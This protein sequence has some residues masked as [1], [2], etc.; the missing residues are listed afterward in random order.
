MK[1]SKDS[2]I[3]LVVIGA[4]AILIW[5]INFL[6]GF[7][8]LS[9]EQSFC[10][11]Y[12]RVDGL[13]KSS[14]V[15]LR[16]YKI[17]QIKSIQFSSKADNL[18]VEFSISDEF[19]LPKDTEARIVSSDIMGTKEIQLHPGNSK[20]TLSTGDTL[21]GSME[22]DL[23]EQVSMQMLPLKRKAE[24][25]MS[26]VD[27]VLSV[28]Q[29]IFNK[30]TRENLTRSFS[31]IEQTFQKLENTSGTLDTIVTGQKTHMENI[32][33]N[34]DSITTNL[35]ENNKNISNILTNFSSI[36]DS[37][38]AVEIAETINNAKLTLKQS[39]EIL[40]KINSGQGSMGM[41]IN[42][43]TLYMNLEAASNSL[44]NLLIDLKNNPKKYMHFSLF[45]TGKTVYMNS[46]KTKKKLD[47]E[48]QTHYRVQILSSKSQVDLNDPI[49]KGHKKI[50]EVYYNGLYKYTLE[51][52][53]NYKE[54]IRKLKRI[55][56]DFP[57]AFI[58]K[59][60]PED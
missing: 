54:I 42:N 59:I 50:E 15:T 30:D 6:K 33:S 12:E 51:D 44:T 8:M 53:Q 23:K 22:G 49:F 19:Q 37:L 27:S 45:D 32:I 2:I 60:T 39:N 28:I 5:G 36:S 11:K 40:E 57:D 17:G 16:G 21:L 47:K 9:S 7:N 35:K 52:T 14:P 55:K 25:L 3:G 18:I 20:L 29:Y 34:V 24:N 10:A 48:K 56:A 4:I 13:K 26:S 31:S 38:K 46:N 1:I 43:D 58:I 41:L